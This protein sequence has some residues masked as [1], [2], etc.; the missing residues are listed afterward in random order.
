MIIEQHITTEFF[1]NTWIVGNESTKESIII[2]PGDNSDAII[3]KIEK[4]KLSPTIILATHTHPD[5]ISA[6]VDLQDK[7][8]IPFG[9]HESDI[10]NLENLPQIAQLLGIGKVKVPK[11]SIILTDGQII[12]VCGFRVEVIHTPGHTPGSV[13]FSI[14][15][16][17]FVGDT[18][19]RNSIGRTDLPG[20][21]YEQLK[22]SLLNILKLPKETVLY[23]GHGEV[24]TIDEELSNNPFLKDIKSRN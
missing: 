23:P 16:I 5:H 19:F 8:N 14:D 22:K 20:G 21:S 1:E 9:I 13:C 18:I 3:Y 6:V 2:D 12:N 7:Y 4:L 10:S 17:L 15:G 11:A 24:T